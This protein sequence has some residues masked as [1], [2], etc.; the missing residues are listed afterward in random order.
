MSVNTNLK[1]SWRSP[2]E[3]LLDL[4]KSDGAYL[5]NYS[6]DDIE[7]LSHD[8]VQE[9]LNELGQDTSLAMEKVL[10]CI[11]TC[12]HKSPI[13]KLSWLLSEDVRDIENLPV[14]DIEALPLN[15]VEERLRQLGTNFHSLTDKAKNLAEQANK[16]TFTA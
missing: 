4:L 5:E 16:D 10:S 12:E 15:D 6:S 13:H 8:E 2:A 7:K 1:V 14:Q 3:K 11:R 9:R